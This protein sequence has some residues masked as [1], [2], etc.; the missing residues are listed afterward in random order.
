MA[1]M[2]QSYQRMMN[3]E[4]RYVSDGEM[5]NGGVGGQYPVGNMLDGAGAT[6][7]HEGQERWC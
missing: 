4:A 5:K 7:S 3:A 2:W 6:G 1:G